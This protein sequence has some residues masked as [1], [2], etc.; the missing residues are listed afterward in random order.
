[1]RRVGSDVSEEVPS[2][3]SNLF[4]S[5]G[6]SSPFPPRCDL[7]QICCPYIR[8]ASRCPFETASLPASISSI[9][10]LEAYE[11]NI[12]L[13]IRRSVL[14]SSTQE[15][16]HPDSARAVATKSVLI[17]NNSFIVLFFLK[18]GRTTEKGA[19]GSLIKYPN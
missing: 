15:T 3:L 11:T 14:S 4:G 5:P 2:A 17:F 6:F 12:W 10:L 8:T 16:R 1:S 19:G 18:L 9:L 7:L 13:S